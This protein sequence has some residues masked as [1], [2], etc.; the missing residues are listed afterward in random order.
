MTASRWTGSRC[1]SSSMMAT[2]GEVWPPVP[3]PVIKP[4]KVV[5]PAEPTTP[6]PK[7]KV[8][9]KAA[10]IA[11]APPAPEKEYEDVLAQLRERRGDEG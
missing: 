2:A 7:P 1:C 5:L 6:R 9:A 10:P 4:K 8:V 3:P 11:K